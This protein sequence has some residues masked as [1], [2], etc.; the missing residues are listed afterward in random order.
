MT[1]HV[2]PDHYKATAI[3][4]IEYQKAVS[5]PA[6]FRGYLR[7]CATKYLHR[8]YTKDTPKENLDKAIWYL[9][10]L[11]KEIETDGTP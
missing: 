9:E 6:E 10:R 5:T 11:R 7:L 4:C 2:N 8:L 1:D 3:E